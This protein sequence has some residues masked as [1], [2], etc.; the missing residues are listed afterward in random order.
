MFAV[1]GW[2]AVWQGIE[3]ADPRP[4]L[5]TCRAAIWV[6][7]MWG[8]ADRDRGGGGGVLNDVCPGMLLGAHALQL[9]YR[10]AVAGLRRE[11]V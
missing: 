9:A 5:G 7:I 2:A 6:W 8:R 10:C 4:T 3:A 1:A 11:F